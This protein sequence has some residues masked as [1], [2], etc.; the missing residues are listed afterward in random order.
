MK[1]YVKDSVVVGIYADE[2]RHAPPASE[3]I[4]VELN[5]QTGYPSPGWT[6]DGKK[7]SM[8]EV[9][10]IE[11][12]LEQ[13]KEIALKMID[14]EA[15]ALH[16]T[17]LGDNAYQLSIYTAKSI[18]GRAWQLKAF[19]TEIDAY[20][21]IKAEMKASGSSPDA[22]AAKF[23]A[24]YTTLV[25]RLAEIE[26]HRVYGKADVRSAETKEAVREAK[27]YTFEKFAELKA[28]Y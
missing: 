13:V 24:L 25:D 27:A 5:C 9:K 2:D 4:V 6:Y 1:A 3:H 18:D 23:V 8:P 28:G 7:F 14:L 11:V 19:G 10:V 12:S 17:L 15:Q 20:R 26:E 22:V 21:W 16:K